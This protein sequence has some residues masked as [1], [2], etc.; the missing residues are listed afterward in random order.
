[1]CAYL[2]WCIAPDF[3][4]LTSLQTDKFHIGFLICDCGGFGEWVE[5]EGIRGKLE[6]YEWKDG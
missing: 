2:M 5:K 3:R 4:C 1:M 6:G